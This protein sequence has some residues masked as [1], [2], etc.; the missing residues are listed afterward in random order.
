MGGNKLR[1]LVVSAVYS[2]PADGSYSSSDE[3]AA[4]QSGEQVPPRFLS[5]LASQA[6]EE[7]LINTV[8]GSVAAPRGAP[9]APIACTE[10]AG[11]RR[12]EVQQRAGRE[13]GGASSPGR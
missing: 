6:D 8:S 1:H 10:A 3:T 2:G 9:L 12:P 13:P 11:G 4:L 5:W 7:R